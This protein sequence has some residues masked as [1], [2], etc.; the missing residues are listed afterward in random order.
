MWL[1]FS[2][3]YLDL[4]MVKDLPKLALLSMMSNMNDGSHVESP[5]VTYIKV[6]S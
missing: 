6:S 3:G 2:D 4:I 1:Q 5:Y